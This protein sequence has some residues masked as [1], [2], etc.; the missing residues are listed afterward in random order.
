MISLESRFDFGLQLKTKNQQ[1]V[2]L[3]MMKFWFWEFL[4]T[5]LIR[6]KCHFCA[7]ESTTLDII[8]HVISAYRLTAF[9][10]QIPSSLIEEIYHYVKLFSGN[11]DKNNISW[12]PS[13]TPSRCIIKFQLSL[14]AWWVLTLFLIILS[15]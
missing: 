5:R 3:I 10:I 14:C 12:C 8:L 6:W 2:R 9:L 1:S 13:L 11:R 7:A 4:N 15:I